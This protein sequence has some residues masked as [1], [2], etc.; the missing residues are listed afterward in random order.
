MNNENNLHIMKTIERKKFFT[1][2]AKGFMGLVLVSSFPFKLFARNNSSLKKVEIKINPL[3][4]SRDKD[5]RKN[6]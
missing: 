4:V 1:K 6:G 5:N 2:L 3:A